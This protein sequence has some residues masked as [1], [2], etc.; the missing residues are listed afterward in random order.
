MRHALRTLWTNDRAQDLVE[1]GLALSIIAIAA[2]AV[3]IAVRVD[4]NSLW[5]NAQ[6]AVHAAL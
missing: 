6:T 5:T 3:A 1:Y 2:G 4:I